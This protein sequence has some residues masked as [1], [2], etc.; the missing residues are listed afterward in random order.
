MKSKEKKVIAAVL[1]ILV[2]LVLWKG[3]HSSVIEDGGISRKDPGGGDRQEALEAEVEGETYEVEVSVGERQ[4]TEKE[5]K[6]LIEAAKKEVDRTFPGENASL[7]Q[8]RK[9]VVMKETYQE[10]EVEAEWSLDTYDIIDT[11]GNFIK[12]DLAKEGELIGAG[13]LLSCGDVR[14]E[15]SFSFQVHAPKLSMKEQIA[16]ALEREEEESKTKKT[17]TLP[18]KIGGK[19]IVWRERSSHPLRY[20]LLLGVVMAALLKLRGVEEE[21]KKKKKREAELLYYYPQLVTTLSLL[22]GAGMTVSKAWERMV[23]RY[24]EGK[25]GRKNEA[26]EEMCHTWNEIQEGVGERKAYENFGIRCNLPQY[27]KLS[28]LLTQNLRK[29]TAGMSEL[30][31][32]EA[33]LALE[34]RKNLAK[35]LGEEAGTKMLLPMMMMLALVMVIVIV[36]AVISF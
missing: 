23:S 12:T 2:L 22:L 7:N 19:E 16:A 33:E 32:K 21:R 9:P 1:G 36:P 28:S 15:Y 31:A 24:R 20:I 6:E 13:V 11:E 29:G 17:F 34:Q 27:K 8:V 3:A 14:E 5:A 26:Y 25:E 4:Y 35:K 18:V 10:G 30:L